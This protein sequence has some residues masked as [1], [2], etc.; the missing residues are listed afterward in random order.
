MESK[1]LMK[2]EKVNE[3]LPA[4]L[5]DWQVSFPERRQEKFWCKWRVMRA[6][7]KAKKQNLQWQE[8][9]KEPQ[10]K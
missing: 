8:K 9:Q 4:E 3:D 5:S 1:Q 7:T 2:E 10:G 6:R